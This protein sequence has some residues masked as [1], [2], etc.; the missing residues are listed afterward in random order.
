MSMKYFFSL[1]KAIPFIVLFSVLI[2]ASLPLFLS[3]F[4]PTHDGE[5]HII[6]FFEFEKMFRSGY[7]FPRWA[8]GFNS[9]YGVPLFNFFYP[10]PNYFGSLFHSLGWSL[11]DAFKLSMAFGYIAAGLFCFLWLK[12]LFGS[13]AA[14]AGAIVFSFVPYWFVD[15]YVRGS[16]GEIYAVSFFILVLAAI[17]NHWRKTASLGVAGMILSHNILAI[18]FLPIILG[19]ILIRD[20]SYIKNVIVGIGLSA[21]FWLPALAERRYVVGLNSVN[22]RDYFPQLYQLLIPSWGTGFSG[23]SAI[24]NEMSPQIGVIPLVII[25][26]SIFLILRNRKHQMAK[27][28]QYFLFLVFI[29]FVL[30]QE[31]SLPIWE[32]IPFLPLLQYPWRLLSV[33]FPAIALFSAF[34]FSKIGNI[35][36]SIVFCICAIVLSYAY[37]RP[38]MYV[39]RSDEYYL[40]RRNF[41]DGTSSLGNSFSTRW[42]DWKKERAKE[43][44]EIIAGLAKVSD[45]TIKPVFYS[46]HISSQSES[47]LRVNSLYYPGWTVEVNQKQVPIYYQKDGIITFIASRGE[48]WVKVY[49]TETPLRLISDFLSLFSLFWLM[50]SAILK[51]ALRLCSGQIYAYR[52]RFHTAKKRA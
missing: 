52:L 24:G 1:K 35:W 46:F 25:I 39:S 34:V 48:H 14:V 17:D 32:R 30:M 44:V 50:R 8:P 20:V 15:I 4:L 2:F 49:F 16:I 19:Y 28:V 47:T 7:I 33:F 5:Y 10:L 31:F 42:S 36:F 27:I 11:T 40:T 38:A 37:T 43:S 3:G 29:S 23:N 9:G 6:R 41:T 26:L 12:K 18:I 22:F 51:R 13:A 45:I 21:Y